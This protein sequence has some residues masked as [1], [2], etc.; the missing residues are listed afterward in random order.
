MFFGGILWTCDVK[1]LRIPVGVWR[2]PLGPCHYPVGLMC[3]SAD[4]VFWTYLPDSLS[5]VFR[6][7]SGLNVDEVINIAEEYGIHLDLRPRVPSST[8]TMNNPPSDAIGSLVLLRMSFGG[9]DKI[10]N[11]FC[12]SLKNWKDRF[13]LI[14]LRAIPDAMPWRHHDSSVSDPPPISVQAK[15]VLRLCENVID[16][17]PVHP[18][19]LYEI[20]LTT[21]WKHARHHPAFKDGE[22]NNNVIVLRTYS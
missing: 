22:R 18:T 21:I 1:V 15:D 6:Y 11:E 12:S 2:R 7:P 13:F 4:T 14:D 3:W 16:L 8:M 20:R 9:R 17:R 19:M 5:G 10:F